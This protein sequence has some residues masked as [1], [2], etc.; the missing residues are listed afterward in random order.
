[1]SPGRSERHA[2]EPEAEDLLAIAR[3]GRPHGVRGEIRG[4]A[5]CPP[6]LSFEALMTSGP[7]WLR[8]ENAPLESIEVEAL[9]PHG[10]L[11][12]VTLEGVGD[13]DA[14]EA[15]KQAELCLEREALPDLPE[16]WYWEADLLGLAVED[17]RRGPIG[18]A[19]G[20]EQ[21]GG[22]HVLVVERE[23]PTGAKIQVPWAEAL[24]TG[25][26]REAGRIEVDLP[27]EY[28]GLT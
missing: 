9:R 21:L 5:L 11:W 15:F 14:A 6:V 12:L 26:D 18:K 3:L 8:R 2:S 28:P 24:V 17:R 1:M 25:I 27:D 23:G 13:R 22:Q 20:L 16:G 10:Q 4:E 19:A 7:L